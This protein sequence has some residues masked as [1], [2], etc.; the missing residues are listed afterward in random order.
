V[1]RRNGHTFNKLRDIEALPKVIGFFG[2]FR[3]AFGV[4]FRVAHSEMLSVSGRHKRGEFSGGLEALRFVRWVYG[5]R[6]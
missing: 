3:R 2:S 6:I 1:P 4:A 5:G